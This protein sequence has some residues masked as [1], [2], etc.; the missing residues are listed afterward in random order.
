[1]WCN[2]L[3]M[4]GNWKP[5]FCETLLLCACRNVTSSPT[6][7]VHEAYHSIILC[8]K[9]PQHFS[10]HPPWSISWARGTRAQSSNSWSIS[11]LSACQTRSLVAIQR[12][13]KRY[14][15]I[16][17]RPSCFRS[18][19]KI[20]FAVN[21]FKH[22]VA[23]IKIPEIYFCGKDKKN[24]YFNSFHLSHSF[25]DGIRVNILLSTLLLI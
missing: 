6:N 12:E 18:Y 4:N 17:S 21:I 15:H 2:S 3:D 19:A 22:T 23:N 20:K 7:C 11:P 9:R 16:S 24:K 1:M 14:M 10:F 5:R 25:G 13:I 8:C